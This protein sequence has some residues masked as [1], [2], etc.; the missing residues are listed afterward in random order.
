PH[1]RRKWGLGGEG[2]QGREESA[3]ESRP[4]EGAEGENIPRTTHHSPRTTQLPITH[5]HLQLL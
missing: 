3:W 1:D 2:G 5:Y 4:A